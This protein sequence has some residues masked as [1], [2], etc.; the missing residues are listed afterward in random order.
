M[1]K[2]FHSCG[3]VFLLL[4]SLFSALSQ[5][6]AKWH[7]HALIYC[8]FLGSC[9]CWVHKV[10]SLETPLFLR[11]PILHAGP[12]MD[13]GIVRTKISAIALSTVRERALLLRFT[14]LQIWRFP[15]YDEGP[16]REREKES[17]TGCSLTG[18]G[19]R[20]MYA[21]SYWQQ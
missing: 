20:F 5:S 1:G 6:P 8:E 11:S 15:N 4:L 16:W 21:S 18:D 14:L 17:F 13:P 3:A 9:V 12:W 2:I 19:P 7:W 10:C